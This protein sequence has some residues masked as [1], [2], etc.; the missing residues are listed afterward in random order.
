M[1]VVVIVVVVVV[2]VVVVVVVIVVV[3]VVVI[4][5]VVVSICLLYQRKGRGCLPGF[6]ADGDVQWHSGGATVRW[7]ASKI[8][9]DL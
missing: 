9:S 5:G 1:V 3:V 2:I 7:L 4:V 8:R 6:G